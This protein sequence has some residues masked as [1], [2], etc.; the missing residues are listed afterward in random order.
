[1][2]EREYPT[3]GA[4]AAPARTG[5]HRG[6]RTR[7]TLLVLA[8]A[9]L[10]LGGVA[11]AGVQLLSQSIGN[12]VTRI[13]HVFAQPGQSGGAPGPAPTGAL[14]FLLAGTDSR[15]PDPTTGTDATAPDFV[16]GAQR[17][18]V[19]MLVRIGADRT[20][21]SVVS[22]PRD[23]WVDVPGHGLNKIN[24]AFSYGGPSLMIQTVQNLTGQHVDH[25]G[26]IDFAGFQ[27]M[28]DA[29]GGIDVQVAASTSSRG[30]NFHPGLNHL[31][32]AQALVYVRER[33]DLPQGDL[34]RAHREQNALRA[35]LD[36]A[37][38]SGTLSNPVALFH[39]IDA[40][41]RAVSVDDTLTNAGLRSLALELRGMRPSGVT[42][43]NAPVS[44][45]GREGAQSV[46]YLDQGRA[47]QLW[48]A[49]KAGTVRAY[50]AKYP[51]DRL[52]AAP[53]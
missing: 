9:V 26:V 51:G 13:P 27:A 31:D 34:D 45:F 30:V 53:A 18:D 42:F 5:R 20:S 11:V 19:L 12:N 15:S 2:T 17:S 35:L 32:G 37:A 6:R 3:D 52:A 41:S 43:L 28:V 44:G 4:A 1:M 38:S 48:A 33:Y 14:T 47:A 10:L 46:V 29:V 16:Y 25:F 8:V 49:L 40:S 7:R 22:L 24:A 23:S 21:A 50:A 39:L 36:K